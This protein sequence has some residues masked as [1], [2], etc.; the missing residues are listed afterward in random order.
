[1]QSRRS[2]HTP[3]TETLPDSGGAGRSAAGIGNAARQGALAARLPGAIPAVGDLDYYARRH[4]DFAERH[5]ASDRTPP[6][7]YLGYGD[8]YVRRFSLEVGPLLSDPGQVWLVEVRRLLQEAIEGERER[9]PT[10]FDRLEQDSAA[11]R[12]F[13]FDTHPQ[14]YW[15]AGLGGL[16]VSDLLTIGLTPDTPDLLSFDGLG[17][18]ANIAGRLLG[19]WGGEALDVVLWDG[20]ADRLVQHAYAGLLV[21]GEGLDLVFGEGA[22]HRLQDAAASVGAAVEDLAKNVHGAIAGVFTLGRNAHDGIWGEGATDEALG[23]ARIAAQQGVERVEDG[24]EWIQG[25]ADSLAPEAR[26]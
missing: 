17:Q 18:V 4:D 8:K 14:C 7:Y 5:E 16:P 12:S 25:L 23:T 21:V 6:D 2:T 15:D 24:L 9:D 19:A 3:S 13:A 20:A 11:F 26:V 10:G 1:M 22:T